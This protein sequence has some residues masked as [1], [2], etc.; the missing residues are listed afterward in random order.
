MEGILKV[1]YDKLNSTAGEFEGT[2]T[3][4]RN[5]TGEMISLIDSLKPV[6]T[7]DA[8]DTYNTKFHELDDDIE[9]MHSM[10][11]EHVK[12]LREMAAKYQEAEDA[13]ITTGGGL[14]G[15]VIS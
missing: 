12:D 6:W 11:T 9:R 1:D 4:V 15:N 7:G 3:Q 14:S 5:L 13:N 2:G 10:I 8:A